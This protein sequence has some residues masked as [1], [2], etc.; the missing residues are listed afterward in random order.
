M[1]V[2][3][4]LVGSYPIFMRGV[5]SSFFELFMKG[6]TVTKRANK[7]IT[8]ALLAGLTST[9]MVIKDA[10]V[11]VSLT[12]AIL[13]SAIIYMFPSLI[14]LKLTKRLIK[15]GKLKETFGVKS[16]R[17]ANKFLIILGVALGVLG[18]GVTL[19]VV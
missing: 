17:L 7:I 6:K 5:K 18:T 13:G 15:E 12:G 8:T 14:Y 4:S 3:I 10:G 16:E 1:I 2:T 9:A 19:G 11:M